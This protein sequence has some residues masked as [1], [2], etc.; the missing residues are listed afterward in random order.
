MA[1]LADFRAQHPEYNDMS[2]QSL[3]DALYRKFY[4]DMPREQFDAKMGEQQPAATIPTASPAPAKEESYSESWP[5]QI[6]S[7]VN[8]GIASTLGAPVDLATAGLNLASTGANTFLGTD[9]P[10][11]E[12]PVGGG[13]TFRQLLSPTIKEESSDPTKQMARRVAKE[14]GAFVIPGMGPIAKSAKPLA[15]VGKELAAAVGSGTGAA[16]ANQALPDNPL[17]EI[18]GQ[19]M[20]GF[21]PGAI[22]RTLKGATKK[23]AAPSSELLRQMKTITYKQADNL[24]VAYSPTAFDNLLADMVGSVKAENI[25]PDRHRAAYSLLVDLSKKR[26]QPIS[27]TELD[28]WR[29]II[30]RDLITPSYGNPAMSADAHF[31][32]MMLDDI[33]NFIDAARG[34]D[35]ISG[36]PQ[37]AAKLIVAARGLNTRLRKTEMIEDALIKA[38]RQAESTGS[39]GNINNAIRQK[40]RA[41]L[42]NPKKVRAFTAEERKAMEGLVRQGKIE[43]LLRWVGKFSPGGNGLIGMLT[44]GGTVMNPGMAALPVAGMVAKG[45]ADAGTI[46]KAKKLQD[47]VAR[48]SASAIPAPPKPSDGVLQALFAAQAANQLQNGRAD[49]TVPY[50][51]AH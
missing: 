7:G 30:R 50:G 45:A 13:D 2:D 18:G 42:D 37:K 31:G 38:K 21:S 17:A 43:D 26:G 16:I 33:D 35:V 41:I 9:L 32:E 36:D 40:I 48:G 44:I 5:S 49:I 4:S 28:H 11:I 29:Q 23:A 19:L 47:M 6:L 1:G 20:G 39:G 27:L 8:E 14:V 22:A 24:G 15:T 10:Q 34:G 25:S 46:N 12:H 3:S 51:R